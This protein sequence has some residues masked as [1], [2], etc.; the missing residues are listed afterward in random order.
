MINKKIFIYIYMNNICKLLILCIVILF[1][2]NNITKENFYWTASIPT[3]FLNNRSYN[4]NPSY[5]LRG[6]PYPPPQ[7]LY[8]R[9]LYGSFFYGLFPL[10]FQIPYNL[11]TKYK[12]YY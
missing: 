4:I 7:H 2:K 9:G 12:A 1:L 8:N 10:M 11:Y 6:D 5:D 3:R